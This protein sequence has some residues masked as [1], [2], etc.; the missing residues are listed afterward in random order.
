MAGTRTQKNQYNMKQLQKIINQMIQISLQQNVRK[1]M[2]DDGSKNSIK[3]NIT[4]KSN[5]SENTV[6]ST[7]KKKLESAAIRAQKVKR[8]ENKI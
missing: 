7:A 6:G 8:T 1:I 5:K 3:N 2:T 4:A